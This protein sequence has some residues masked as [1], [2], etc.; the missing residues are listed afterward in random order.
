LGGLARGL[1]ESFASTWTLLSQTTLYLSRA[2]LLPS[3]ELQLKAWRATLVNKQK[4]KLAI[5]L[6]RDDL[7]QLRKILRAEGHDLALGGIN[8]DFEGFRDDS[9]VRDGFRRLAIVISGGF[10][11]EITGEDNHIALGN[12]LS[13]RFSRIGNSG[14]R[15][16]HFL[17]YK[18]KGDTIRLSGSDTEGKEDFRRLLALYEA[19]PLVLLGGLKDLR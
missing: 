10:V 2:G 5:S 9:C 6:L 12:H 11:M 3:Y 14:A 13:E 4:D 15:E 1:A 16:F 18:R 17:W 8:I 19:R 7:V